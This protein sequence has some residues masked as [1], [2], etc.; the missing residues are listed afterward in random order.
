M[1]VKKGIPKRYPFFLYLLDFP[2]LCFFR[3][4][5]ALTVLNGV[6]TAALADNDGATLNTRAA[7]V[8]E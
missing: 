5:Y 4:L 8:F 2:D 1:K 3:D 7:D 6:Y